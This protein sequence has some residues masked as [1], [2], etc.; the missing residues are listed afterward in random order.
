MDEVAPPTKAER[1]RQIMG[2]LAKH[3]LAAVGGNGSQ[4]KAE[5]ARLAC[6]E[7]GTTFI[8]LGQLLSTRGDMLSE[9]YLVEFSKL[10]DSVPPVETGSIEVE[11]AESLGASPHELFGTF[12]HIPLASASIGQ[13][14]AATLQD[15]RD[16][17][18]K[19]R[20]PGVK[21]LVEIDLD[22][23]TSL[24]ASS[25]KRFP[26]IAD[27]DVRGTVAEFTDMLRAELDYTREARHVEQ[28]GSFFKND[29]GF[30]LP[31]VIWEFCTASV[32]VLTV[33]PGV[34]ASELPDLTVKL[35]GAV[36]ERIARFVLEPA[37]THGVFYAD[38]HPGNIS[39]QPNGTVGVVDFGMIGTLT[40]ETRR[41]LAD[42][43]M[44]LDRRDV[45]RFTD[46]LID[47]APP[48]RPIDRVSLSQELGRLIERYM[49]TS[50]EHVQLGPA[51]NDLLDLVRQRALH[52]SGAVA[53]FFKA[54]AMSEGL[55]ESIDPK[56][57]I[58]DFI[59]PISETI[60]LSRLTSEE[61]L[62]RMKLS[63]VDAAELGIDLPRR[64][65]R[66]LADIER[67][68]LRVW[69]RV[70]DLEPML[71]RMERMVERLNV[72]LIAAACIVGLAI[73]LM[74]YHPQGLYGVI[75]GVVWAAI[76]I[77][78]LAVLRILWQTLRKGG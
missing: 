60:S 43:F 15:G 48:T 67:G 8:K 10:Q 14:H 56:K 23:L 57:T 64:A 2:V 73:L 36:T 21:E 70:E 12:E 30:A 41:Y 17:V 66:V 72:T 25:A 75:G 1:Q 16:V 58:A 3:G 13:V 51:I 77:A 62:E 27:F 29:K 22:I 59:K 69:T 74:Y 44:A 31:Q 4:F 34:K 5:Q 26:A 35:R 7:L 40:D 55:I 18:V 63:A 47:V 19:V 45:Q 71:T 52:L 11:I 32:L 65:D 9:E 68:N 33:V 61:W 24:A 37:F 76:V 46:R 54:I 20:K 42:L 38:P 6:E 39:I 53:M 28:F 49:S 50:L 78:V